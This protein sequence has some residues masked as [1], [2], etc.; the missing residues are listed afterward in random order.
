VASSV[1]P[2]AATQVSPGSFRDPSGHVFTLDGQVF[3][4]INECYAATYEQVKQSGLYDVLVNE[5]LLV[6]HAEVEAPAGYPDP[7]YRILQ[8]ER[9]PFISYPFEWSFSQL[10]SAALLTLRVQRAA[11]DLGLT[12]K[13]AS[14]YNVQFRGVEPV[15]IDTLS[16]EPWRDGTPWVAYRQFCQH[17]LGPLA[18]MSRCDLRLGQLLRVHLDGVPLDL[19]SRLLPWSSVLRPTLLMHLHLHARAQSRHGRS[20]GPTSR[21]AFGRRAMLGLIESLETAI[22]GMSDRGAKGPWTDYYDRTNYSAAAMADKQQVVGELL[23]RVQPRVVWDLGA[24]TGLF[25]RLAVE[26]GAYTIAFDGDPTAVERHIADCRSRGESRVLPLVMDFANPTGG[27]GWDHAERMSLSDRGPASVL[28]ALGLVHHL[29]I[30]NQVPFVRVA[31]S[32][33]RLGESL[34]VELPSAADSQV[35]DM[36]ARAPVHASSY[37]VPAFEAAFA[38]CFHIED[39]RPIRDSERRLYLMRGR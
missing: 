12:L 30:A 36:L 28:L 5:R 11:V 24:N 10:K 1:R 21:A 4:H 9:I 18:L 14:A 26:T 7:C 15:H 2:G 20:T 38:E 37:T 23:R 8:P 6:P 31:E 39:I 34:I 22:E 35:R 19:V 32:F 33:R 16:F 25:S 29:R 3:R 27:F 17:F 13:D